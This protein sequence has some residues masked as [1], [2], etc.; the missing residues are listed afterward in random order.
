MLVVP[1]GVRRLLRNHFSPHAQQG[2]TA[3]HEAS[4]A[5]HHVGLPHGS[6]AQCIRLLAAAGSDANFASKVRQVKQHHRP[7]FSHV[8]PA[9]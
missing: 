8:W 3:L 7:I 6:H 5:A 4:Q 1:D 2:R 9:S